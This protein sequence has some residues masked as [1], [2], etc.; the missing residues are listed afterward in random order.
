MNFR[1]NLALSKP[2]ND[3]TMSHGQ[4][5]K[6]L[7]I[8]VCLPVSGTFTYSVTGALADKVE[9]GKRAMVSF[10]KRRVI[11]YILKI[12]PP[13]DR[14]GI[15]DILSVLDP[16]PLFPQDMVE[17]FEWLSSYY[18]YPIGLVI[19]AA[20]PTGLNVAAKGGQGTTSTMP[21]PLPARASQRQAGFK[22][23]GLGGGGVGLL[24]RV[25]IGI[26]RGSVIDGSLVGLK[27][28]ARPVDVPS[29]EAEAVRQLFVHRGQHAKDESAFLELVHTR[30]EMPLSEITEKF[31]NG[32]YLV[33]K[34]VKKGI[35]EKLLKPV[36]RDLVSEDIFFSPQ[37]PPLNPTQ[38][39]I[40]RI[41]EGS[42]RQ[43][44]Y[45]AFLLHGVTGSGKTEVYFDAVRAAIRLGKQ[46]IIMVPE[47]ALTVSLAS[48]FK[49]RLKERVAVFHSALSQ[50]QRYEQWISIARGEAD[51][52]I[53]ARSA[54]F[55]PLPRLGLIIL[56]EEHDTSYK[57]E[58]KFRYQARDAAVMRSK[59]SNAVVILGSGTPSVQS[60]QN[61]VAGKY[62]L[63][64]MPERIG[65][66]KPPQ[67]SV[68]NMTECE[69]AT[70]GGGIL[71]QQLQE[72]IGEN[73]AKGEQ[74]ILFLNR[75]GFSSLYLC[76]FCGTTLRCPNCDLSLTYHKESDTLLC[77]YCGFRIQPPTR[78]PSCGK[79]Q[80]KPYGFGTERVTETLLGIF[81]E[82]RVERMDRDTMRHKDE[83]QQVLKR[84]LHRETDV[85]VGTQMVTKG[86]DFPHVTLVG[87]ISADLSLN[88]PDF[89]AGETTFQ[90]ISQV[91]GRTGRGA[92]P[93]KVI[94]QT[95]N[96]SHYAIRAARDHDYQGFFSREIELRRQLNYPPFSSMVNL[97]FLGNSRST[98]EQIARNMNMRIRD[99]LKKHPNSKKDIEVL[100]P[101]EAPIAKIKG[102]YR[103]QILIK[104]RRPAY[105]NQ[106]L[107]E[108]DRF[109]PQILGPSGV[110]LIMDVDPYQMI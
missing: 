82:A 84:F 54:L 8:A 1:I 22:G 101:V 18:R 71:S 31:S 44:H 100:G 33:D 24:K 73:L 64:S 62:G 23:E 21:S 80:L 36:A 83:V 28:G 89:R 43:N 49:A 68:I 14:K 60:Y 5:K 91:A 106:L 59:L 96:P 86:H 102:K 51:V 97:R 32:R 98:T 27:S 41:I 26:K 30:G 11:G 42:M 45:R 103:Q 87:V 108:I 9:A 75:R 6:H 78:C 61:A 19:K 52:V 85:L 47:I 39:E 4:E 65:K 76:R 63:L 70:S 56:D 57:Q 105:L 2:K 110:R 90:L 79:E 20:L 46:S 69:D 94:I 55:A 93:G 92:S 40:L 109:S 7:Q 50:G 48:L 58:E 67:I 53:G 13:E 107:G 74:T 104:S 38:K 3:A 16:L 66:K 72:G 81:P 17:F 35:L 34:W 10:S 29:G 37:P 99:T 25:F 95:Y 77:H 12:I 15:K 88:W